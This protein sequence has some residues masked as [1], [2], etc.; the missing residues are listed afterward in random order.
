MP[1]IKDT[2][3]AQELDMAVPAHFLIPSGTFCRI[4]PK[5]PLKMAISAH[6]P[7]PSGKYPYLYLPTG[8]RMIFCRAAG[9]RM[10]FCPLSGHRMA[11][12]AHLGILWPQNT[13]FRGKTG[14]RM[15]NTASAII[16]WQ[17][18]ESGELFF[19]RGGAVELAK[20]RRNCGT[21]EK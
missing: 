19:G 13:C 5:Q 14:H 1:L 4:S 18:N 8:H 21:G 7:I 9:H 20:R 11:G 16:L 3:D 2:K 6:S 15:K 17:E 10:I 12:S